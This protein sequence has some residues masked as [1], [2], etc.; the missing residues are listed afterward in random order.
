MLE[1][2]FSYLLL[3]IGVASVYWLETRVKRPRDE[4]AL[5]EYARLHELAVKKNLIALSG[6]SKVISYLGDHIRENGNWT[7]E[8]ERQVKKLTFEWYDK[9]SMLEDDDP[10]D[11]EMVTKDK[12][13]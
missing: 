3:A 9:L 2:I 11:Y 6:Q 12:G 5:K 10:S 7:P 4:K 1:T 13:E 8:V